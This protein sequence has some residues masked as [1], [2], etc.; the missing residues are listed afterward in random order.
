[1]TDAP[2]R[3]TPDD[4][5]AQLGSMLREG[6]TPEEVAAHFGGFVVNIQAASIEDATCVANRM[7]DAMR[8]SQ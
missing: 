1:M 8:T 2:N 5:P 7:L 6:K 3:S 4:Y